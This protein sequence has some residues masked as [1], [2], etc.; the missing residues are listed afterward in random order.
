MLTIYSLKPRF[1]GLLR[2]LAAAMARAGI[3]ANQVTISA[4]VMSLLVGMIMA[5]QPDARR[6]F[7]LLPV[8]LFVR[9]ALNA[10]DGILAREHGM[11]SALG[12]ILN[13]LGD[14]VSDIALYAPLAVIPSVNGVWLTG[15][16][17]L[18]T[19]SE[20]VGIVAVQIGA[21]R[22]YDGPLGKSD[23]AFV[24]GTLGLL[25]G[26]GVA[27]GFWLNGLLVLLC[28]FSLLTAVNRAHA[29]LAEISA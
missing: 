17:L 20:M 3:T 26:F 22:R 5:L 27:P 24:I 19:I 8:V 14:V 25:L 2:P 11:K 7:L 23:R 6:L 4:A 12:A 18:S 10:V 16:L 29:A 1:Q 9:M 21:S 15:F 13:E 28:V